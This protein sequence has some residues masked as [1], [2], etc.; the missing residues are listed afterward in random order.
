[1]DNFTTTK[2]SKKSNE[3]NAVNNTLNIG[4][5]VDDKPSGNEGTSAG[6]KEV[7]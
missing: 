6:T 5:K 2:T 3:N 7:V 1:M 4:K